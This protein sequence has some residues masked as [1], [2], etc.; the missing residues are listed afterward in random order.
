MRCPLPGP[1]RRRD[2]KKRKAGG[3]QQ[4]DWKWFGSPRV[5]SPL[6]RTIAAEKIGSDWGIGGDF[7]TTTGQLDVALSNGNVGGLCRQN[8]HTA[9]LQ[10]DPPSA[11]AKDGHSAAAAP[12]RT[13]PKAATSSQT[14]ELHNAY[15]VRWIAGPWL[16]GL[17]FKGCRLG[18]DFFCK[19]LDWG[20]PG[21][22]STHFRDWLPATDTGYV[23]STARPPWLK[24]WRR[25]R[26]IASVRQRH[27]PAPYL[28]VVSCLVAAA[29]ILLDVWG[30]DEAATCSD[31]FFG[32]VSTLHAWLFLET[33][34]WSLN[35]QP[36]GLSSASPTQPV[37]PGSCSIHAPRSVSSRISNFDVM[38]PS[39]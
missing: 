27:P 20:L 34:S 35:Y 13:R 29:L 16:A 28:P 31:A 11:A 21:N 12:H 4:K 15:W 33:T 10:S 7:Q 9:M 32:F 25:N 6:S 26:R 18:L 3:K 5:S 36:T 23:Q 24:H 8:H 30:L 1:R 22:H 19:K 39:S 37:S 2:N 14:G 38:L 17:G